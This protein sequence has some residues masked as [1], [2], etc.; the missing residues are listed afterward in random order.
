MDRQGRGE[1]QRESKDS[2]SR[3]NPPNNVKKKK[4]YKG[5]ATSV[6]SDWEPIG[7]MGSI[8]RKGDKNKG[9]NKNGWLSHGG[10]VEK[11]SLRVKKG[12]TK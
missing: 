8:V 1:R 7:S 2:L 12:L 5:A 4:K 3:N 10:G 11:K 9:S 6:R